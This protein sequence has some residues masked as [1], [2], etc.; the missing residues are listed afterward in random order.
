[1]LWE[2]LLPGVIGFTKESRG[3]SALLML[4]ALQTCRSMASWEDRDLKVI[5]SDPD[6]FSAGARKL[7]LTTKGDFLLSSTA[8]NGAVHLRGEV[9]REGRRDPNPRLPAKKKPGCL[10]CLYEPHVGQPILE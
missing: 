1:M 9:V 8:V 2:A 3:M 10:I 7:T 6:L 4:H 5:A